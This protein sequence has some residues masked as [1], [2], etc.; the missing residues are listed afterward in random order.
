MCAGAYLERGAPKYNVLVNFVTGPAIGGARSL[1]ALKRESR[2][3]GM[4]R[5]LRKF[6]ARARCSVFKDLIAGMNFI[7]VKL[8][9]LKTRV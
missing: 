2:S 7:L 3:F 9:M 4:R 6:S 5:P 1:T 8:L